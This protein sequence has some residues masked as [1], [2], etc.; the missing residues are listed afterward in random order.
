MAQIA[1]PREEQTLPLVHFTG[2][3]GIHSYSLV[4]R[5]AYSFTLT[6]SGLIWICRLLI[7][8]YALPVREYE[9]ICWPSRNSYDELA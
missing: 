9:D 2:V 8:E 5:T 3:L 6:I 1:R 4:Y 7:L